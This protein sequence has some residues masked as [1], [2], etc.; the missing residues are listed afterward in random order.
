VQPH[1]ADEVLAALTDLLSPPKQTDVSLNPKVIDLWMMNLNTLEKEPNEVNNRLCRNL[2]T[3]SL[4]DI[5]QE[6]RGW[7][8]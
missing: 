5:G 3:G 6:G 8:Q 1:D 4:L 2:N 7:A